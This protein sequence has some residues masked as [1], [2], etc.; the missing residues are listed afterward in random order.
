MSMTDILMSDKKTH[1]T[2]QEALEESITQSISNLYMISQMS[3]H[4]PTKKLIESVRDELVR[5]RMAY[6]KMHIEVKAQA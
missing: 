3:E 2:K 4:E 6:Y 1:V 5:T